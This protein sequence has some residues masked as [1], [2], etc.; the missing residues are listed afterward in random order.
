MIEDKDKEG[1]IKTRKDVSV[2]KA[3]EH[4]ET[5]R[6]EGKRREVVHGHRLGLYNNVGKNV[7]IGSEKHTFYKLIE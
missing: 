3:N 6:N 4:K 2:K 5:K 7:I 1:K